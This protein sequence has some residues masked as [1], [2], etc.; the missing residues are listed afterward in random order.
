MIGVLLLF[1]IYK[2][3]RKI[4]VNYGKDIEIDYVKYAED[5]DYNYFICL[6]IHYRGSLQFIKIVKSKRKNYNC[7]EIEETEYISSS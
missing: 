4:V 7:F 3:V 1:I 2:M 5:T 6:D